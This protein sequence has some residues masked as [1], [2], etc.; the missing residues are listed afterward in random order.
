MKI[1]A[2]LLTLSFI[3]S[4]GTCLANNDTDFRR[5]VRELKEFDEIEFIGT[6]TLIITQDKE[7]KVTV[8]AD[9][10]RLENIETIV[11]DKT[12]IIRNCPRKWWFFHLD[13]ASQKDA[14]FYVSVD[15]LEGIEIKGSVKVEVKTLHVDDLELYVKGCSDINI[16]LLADRLDVKISGS[17][18]IVVNGKVSEQELKINGAATYDAKNLTCKN[19]EVNMSGTGEVTVQA[20]KTLEVELLGSGNVKY[21]GDPQY[22]D[23]DILGVG[24]VDK[25]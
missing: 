25:L 5:D 2:Y 22:I 21:I 6:G 23:L 15:D 1:L 9:A 19:T 16:H 17:S 18:N 3:L 20:E 7:H 10:K 14:I 12:L 11:D 13:S 4:C 24:N 8:E